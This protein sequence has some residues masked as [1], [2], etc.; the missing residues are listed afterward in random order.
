M[1]WGYVEGLAFKHLG[2]DVTEARVDSFKDAFS[3]LLQQNVPE[4]P[5]GSVAAWRQLLSYT[6]SSYSFVSASYGERLRVIHE[7]LEFSSGPMQ[8]TRM[9]TVVRSFPKMCAFSNEVMGQETEA[10]MEELLQV[11]EVLVEK[12]SSPSLLQEECELLA[13][14]MITKS[15]DIDFERFKPVMMAALR[16][17]LPKTWSTAHETAWE[18]LWATIS[19][20]L[21]EATMKARAFKPYNA[22]LFSVLGEEQLEHFRNTIY[23]DF[24]SKCAASQD[25]F[26]QSQTRLRYIA[27]RVLQSSYDMFPQ[28]QGE[29]KIHHRNKVRY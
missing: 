12:I 19:Q 22:H 13:I 23:V 1:C 5:P 11:F 14:S 20:N 26:K 24:F 10:W 25:L 17:L 28:A 15:K 21:Q 7:D 29:R 16:S 18:W 27:D 4:A 3:E 8:R 2:I 9:R 6:G